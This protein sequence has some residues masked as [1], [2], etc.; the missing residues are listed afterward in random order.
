MTNKPYYFQ[1]FYCLLL[2]FLASFGFAPFHFFFITI[3]SYFL[4][5]K[6]IHSGKDPKKAIFLGFIF[7]SSHNFTSLYWIAI[8]FETGN[9]GGIFLGLAA[10]FFLSLVLAIIFSI[11]CFFINKF[12]KNDF[13]YK[14][15]IK[16]LFMLSVAEWIKGNMLWGFPWMPISAIWAFNEI[17]L[18]PFSVLGTWGYC[19]I[20]YSL[21]IAFLCLREG[22]KKIFIFSLPFSCVL[23]LKVI[24][25][26]ALIDKNKSINIR[27]VQPNIKQE[28]K[29][30]KSK[31]EFNHKKILNLIALPGKKKKSLIILPETAIP[32]YLD[33]DENKNKYLNEILKNNE[34]VI[35]GALRKEKNKNKINIFNS[36]F[37]FQKEKNYNSFHDKVKL[38]PFGEFIP[39]NKIFSFIKITAGYQ[40][41]SSGR[42][43]KV[44]Q[45]NEKIRIL[46]LICYEVIF[47]DLYKKEKKFD[48]AI[49][50]T[51]DAWYRESIGPYQHFA[52]SRIRAVKEGVPLIR[53]ANTGISAIIDAKGKVSSKLNL[54]ET[55]VIDKK[56]QIKEINTIYSNFKDSIFFVAILTLLIYGFF[57]DKVFL[58]KK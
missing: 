53:V 54:N 50:I 40:D 35:V 5:L 12:C 47:P 33:K 48:I 3:L 31:L 42:E 45:I 1:L 55:G 11:A 7:S 51:N 28:E 19:L 6:I 46:P 56:L 43:M 30:D 17:F 26:P 57:S 13:S 4:L 52:H 18:Y 25:P 34:I 14:S 16:I 32:F 37:I 15:L 58:R 39:F 8:S 38:V 27:L 29:W 20:T 10:V 23:F 49:N 9:Y 2:G 24:S 41:F 21:I 44:I 36:M 22:V